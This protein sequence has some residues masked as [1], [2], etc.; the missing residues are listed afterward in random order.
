MKPKAEIFF[1]AV[2][3][4]RE[5]IVEEAQ[6]YHFRKKQSVWKKIGG[7]AACLCLIASLSLLMLPRGCGGSA[8]L[9]AGVDTN[10]APPQAA[11]SCA[12]ADG[13][14]G[15]AISGEPMPEPEEAPDTPGGSY[16]QA[17]ERKFTALVLEVREDSL[18]VESGGGRLIVPTEG[19]TVPELT[20]GDSVL[21][22][23]DGP[24][25]TGPTAEISGVVSIETIENNG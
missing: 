4:L 6:D 20:E 16:G 8:P 5:D 13:E 24:V 10:G 9:G 21:V 2:T 7:L 17:G 19:L 1:D 25:F 3:L 22:T 14:A 18:L 12:P 11:D 15:G 23:Y